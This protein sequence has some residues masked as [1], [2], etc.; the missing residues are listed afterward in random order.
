MLNMYEFRKIT[1]QPR[2][3]KNAKQTF[4]H[5]G[6]RRGREDLLHLIKRRPQKPKA[7]KDG[8]ESCGNQPVS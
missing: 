7:P 2:G 1:T 3:A 5:D 6:F 4:E 8:E